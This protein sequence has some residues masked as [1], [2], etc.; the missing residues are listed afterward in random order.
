MVNA[1]TDF[2][3]LAFIGQGGMYFDMVV[4]SGSSASCRS[5]GAVRLVL[6]IF[7]YLSIWAARKDHDDAVV[8][9]QGAPRRSISRTAHRK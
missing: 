2:V 7:M 9:E 5:D 8:I 1:D 6:I 3:S 4:M